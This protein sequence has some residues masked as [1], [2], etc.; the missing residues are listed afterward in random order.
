MKINYDEFSSYVLMNKNIPVLEFLYDEETHSIFKIEKL[1]NEKHA[2][3]GVV[4]F[5][6]GI[7]RKELNDW[8]QARAIPASRENFSRILQSLKIDS[9]VEL[10][11]KCA[12]FSLSDQYWIKRTD[13]NIQWK[14]LNFFENEFSEDIGRIL[15]GQSSKKINLN[16]V[17]PDN[18]SDGDL[19]KKWKIIDGDR[20]L[21][22]GG[23][24]LNNQ[25]PFNEI[26]AT[27]LY[28]CI[29]D[30]D[31]YV[32]YF[33]LEE[34]GKSYSA[35]KTMVSTEEELVSGYAIDGTIKHYSN[36]SNYHHYIKAGCIL[37]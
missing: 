11:E 27:H 30:K 36:E 16:L 31:D 26:I 19:I 23:N 10:L 9:P 6:T 1:I 12:G 32:P 37:F 2:P 20:V 13:S 5:K 33:L 25:E 7:S 35:C 22:K 24:S 18:A 29:L 15:L 17:S 3:V 21:I 28:E 34:E 8:W 4:N 14:D